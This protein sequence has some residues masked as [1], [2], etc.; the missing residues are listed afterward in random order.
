MQELRSAQMCVNEPKCA[1]R[2]LNKPKKSLN[3]RQ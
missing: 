1:Q 3:E 2:S